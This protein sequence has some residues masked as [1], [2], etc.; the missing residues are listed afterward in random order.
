MVNTS[1]RLVAVLKEL[2]AIDS[3]AVL[4][5][6]LGVSP[7]NVHGYGKG[8]EIS[9]S[10]IKKIILVMM[11]NTVRPLMEIREISPQ[12]IKGK[13]G[14]EIANW[15]IDVKEKD[16]ELCKVLDKIAGVYIFYS[17]SGGVLYVGKAKNLYKEIRQRLNRPLHF[18]ISENM[19]GKGKTFCM[20][21]VT[22]YLSA[23]QVPL[24]ACTNIEAFLIRAFANDH[25]NLKMENFSTWPTKKDIA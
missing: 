23:Y 1:K 22:K 14:V 9:A 18:R 7:A 19:T 12:R 10:Q 3:D 8:G 6:A 20:A 17:S 21:E 4:A 15:R 25:T 2:L 24:E 11:R 16:K 13:A 5:K